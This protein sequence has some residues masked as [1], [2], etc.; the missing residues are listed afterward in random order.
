M[1]SDL[2]LLALLSSTK[3]LAGECERLDK[4]AQI[5]GT[6]IPAHSSGK[7]VIG[8]G[9]LQFYSAP[10]PSCKMP[11]IF[12]LPG[13]D[14][15]AYIEHQKFMSILYINP[16]TSKEAMGWFISERLKSNGFGIGG[17][18]KL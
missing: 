1:R 5:A 13:E 3:V 6:H 14:I 8:K 18:E 17:R 11:G 7:T 15:D 12:I 10:N 2:I 4:D 16:K 9:R